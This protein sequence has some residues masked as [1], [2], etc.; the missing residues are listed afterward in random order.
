M[1]IF[2]TA[3]ATSLQALISCSWQRGESM[4]GASTFVQAMSAC[5]ARAVCLA[6]K[7]TWFCKA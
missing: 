4:Q 5:V 1:T 2:S 7:I 6:A 3:A